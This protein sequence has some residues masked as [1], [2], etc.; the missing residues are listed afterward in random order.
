MEVLLNHPFIDGFSLINNLFWGTPIYGNHHISPTLMAN[1]RMWPRCSE[2]SKPPSKC[3]GSG[4]ERLMDLDLR[5][6]PPKDHTD[7][8]DPTVSRGFPIGKPKIHLQH[9]QGKHGWYLKCDWKLPQS[10]LTHRPTSHGKRWS[11]TRVTIYSWK[12]SSRYAWID[13]HSHRGPVSRLMGL[14]TT[15]KPMKVYENLNCSPKYPLT[16]GWSNLYFWWS[17]PYFWWLNPY[18]WWSN[19]YFSWSNPYFWWLNPYFSWWNPYFSWWNPWVSGPALAM[20]VSQLSPAKPSR[21]WQRPLTQVP[22]GLWPRKARLKVEEYQDLLGW[23]DGLV[24]IGM[25]GRYYPT[26]NSPEIL[27]WQGLGLMSQLLGICFTSP[28]NKYLLEMISHFCWVMW[29]IG[30]FTIPCTRDIV[31]YHRDYIMGYKM[32]YIGIS[33]DYIYTMNTNLSWAIF[34]NRI[35]NGR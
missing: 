27:P 24:G 2:W 29:N 14:I 11:G 19:P 4:R 17:N 33:W 1:C 23:L 25:I 13:N 7:S 21:H 32:G 22:W 6:E 31:G 34:D 26:W 5:K 10:C 16:H 30:T 8:Q 3:D 28:S 20:G 15:L 9:I 18:F 35:H 12:C